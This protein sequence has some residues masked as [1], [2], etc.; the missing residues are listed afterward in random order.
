[1]ATPLELMD[2]R[3]AAPGSIMVSDIIAAALRLREIID[4]ETQCLIHLETDALARHMDEKQ[5]LLDRLERQKN[6]IRRN[7]EVL[8]PYS[9]EEKRDLVVVNRALEQSLT[10][11]AMQLLKVREVNRMVVQAIADEIMRQIGQGQGYTN[12]GQDGLK[13]GGSKVPPLQIDKVI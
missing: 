11:N 10:E 12:K 6:L 13:G 4:E 9:D 3:E 7:K 2:S 1:M 8:A 5:S